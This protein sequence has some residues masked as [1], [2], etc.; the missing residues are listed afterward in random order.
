[1]LNFGIFRGCREEE[2]EEEKKTDPNK[3]RE[4]KQIK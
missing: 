4:Y 1:M 2:E 3:R